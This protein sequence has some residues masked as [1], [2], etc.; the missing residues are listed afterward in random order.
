MIKK[1]A[2]IQ[3]ISNAEKI[4]AELS[5]LELQMKELVQ[6]QSDLEAS[7]RKGGETYQKFGQQIEKLNSQYSKQRNELDQ[8]HSSNR[9]LFQSTLDN[10]GAMGLLS[11]LTG[12]LAMDIKD[13][14]EAT[15]LFNLST[16]AQTAWQAISAIVIGTSTGALKLFRI[17][18]VS[19][20]IGAIVSEF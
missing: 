13:A 5:E 14:V 4:E 3:I 19:T 7:G 18:L 6:A 11:G 15:E 16:K 10:G 17:A 2:E 8:L 9:N 12:G 1:S 20:G